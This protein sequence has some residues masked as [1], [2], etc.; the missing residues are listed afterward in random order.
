MGWILC[1]QTGEFPTRY[2]SERLALIYTF[3]LLSSSSFRCKI[4][5][6]YVHPQTTYFFPSEQA[7]KFPPA[8]WINLSGPCYCFMCFDPLQ[9]NQFFQSEHPG[10]I[11][12]YCSSKFHAASQTH[13]GAYWASHLYLHAR[14]L[15]PALYDQRRWDQL[16]TDDKV[17]C[18]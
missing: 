13:Q 5:Q 11:V 17:R 12:A 6:T 14:R 4:K 16:S 9:S 8:D 7:T 15:Q 18:E 2:L 1:F 3:T 10:W